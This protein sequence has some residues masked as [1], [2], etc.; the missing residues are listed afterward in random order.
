MKKNQLNSIWFLILFFLT[1]CY[2][3][4]GKNFDSSQLK[5]I[6]NNITTKEKILENFGSPFKRGIERGQVMWTYQFD[7]WNALGPAQS[8]DL[9]ILFDQKNIVK[10][11]RYTSSDSNNP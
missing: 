4:I 5:N 6:Q 7:Q 1:A 9:V 3:T 2:G 11:Y 8:K 10:G